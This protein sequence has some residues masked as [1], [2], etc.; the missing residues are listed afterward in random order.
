[1]H[2]K[3]LAMTAMWCLLLTLPAFGE[4]LPLLPDNKAG[5]FGPFFL[6]DSRNLSGVVMYYFT[7]Q[8]QYTRVDFSI[9]GDMDWSRGEYQLNREHSMLF[10]SM[11]E[12]MLYRFEVQGENSG[13]VS[14]A[15]VKTPPYGNQYTIDFTICP[16][17]KIQELNTVPGML[18]VT[19]EEKE[20]SLAEWQS[21]VQS[22][23][24]VMSH[25]III[26]AF[27]ITGSSKLTHHP[28]FNW[29]DYKNARIIVIQDSSL[30]SRHV[31]SM[32][33]TDTESENYLVF[34]GNIE[35]SAARDIVQT[36]Q[37][38]LKGAYYPGAGAEPGLSD[39]KGP[40]T[41]QLAR[42]PRKK[43]VLK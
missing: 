14:Q 23:P 41:V 19:S 36:C 17:S 32:L 20:I 40:L 35:L 1:M 15:S 28:V 3:G 22:N 30:T 8:P 39:L 38:Y 12:G 25:T 34:N 24:Q 42:D 27:R 26:P 4:E 11:E 9:M 33:S 2:N 16:V 43:L 5:E 13:L 29:F 18:I 7:R 31:L 10:S 6:P 21:V 37:P